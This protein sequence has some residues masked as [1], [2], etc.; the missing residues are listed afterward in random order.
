MK[1]LIA[2]IVAVVGGILLWYIKVDKPAATPSPSPS[3]SAN[4]SIS[5]PEITFSYG[6]DFGLATK[7]QQILASSYIP[8][9]DEGFDYCLYYDSPTYKGT[10]FE[11]AGLAVNRRA[12]LKNKTTCMETQPAGYQELRPVSQDNNGYSTSVF[13]GLGDAAAGHYSS[14]TLYRLWTGSVCYDF[15]TRIGES[16]FQ[17]YPAGSIKEFMPSD[18]AF[19]EQRLRDIIQGVSI[20][21]S[22]VHPFK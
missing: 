1:T 4:Q 16:Q 21:A 9:C 14:G 8:P 7:P 6:T 19:L 20:S 2:V 12:D 15:E 13:E 10:N 11:S 5:T 18:R 3:L 17:N 22:G